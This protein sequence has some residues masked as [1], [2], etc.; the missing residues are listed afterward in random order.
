[1][2]LAGSAIL[3]TTPIAVGQ[4]Q[5]LIVEGR[6]TNATPGG[7]AVSGVT[8]V[9]H[10]ES[11]AS[12]THLE[13]TTESTGRFRF[14]GI[15]FDPSVS[16]GI[17][18]KYQGA[19]YGRD[20]ELATG[21]PPP[22]D[23]TVYDAVEEEGVLS[24]SMVS[25][26]FSWA[27][28][29]TQTASALEIVR[30][31]NSSERSYVPGPEPMKLVRFGLPPGAQGLTVETEL[32]GADFVQV[33]RGFALLASIPPGEHEVMY[34]YRFPYTGT[35]YSFSKSFNYGAEQ[36]RVLAPKGVMTLSAGELGRTETVNI[37]DRPYHLV[38]ATD[39][40]RGERISLLLGELPQ[41]S[42]GRRVDRRLDGVRLEYVAP[43]ALG[44]LM[45]AV[46]GYAIWRRSR[47]AEAA[48]GDEGS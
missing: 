15:V 4:E 48:E 6:L 16:Y 22:I 47:L 8:V 30:I 28:P 26:L 46:M 18:V 38:Q 20:V 11:P 42:L 5:D 17:T 9:F 36:V 23:L 19:L 29:S 39:L 1:M 27:D 40:P 2:V 37:G 25:V 3:W 12:H 41:S 33:D 21:S 13:K 10:R 32:L 35:E 43:A 45:A 14:E 24:T 31:I 34:A 44:L 7:A